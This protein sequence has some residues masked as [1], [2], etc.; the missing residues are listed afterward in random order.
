M[1][2]QRQLL[3]HMFFFIFF[4]SK[5]DISYSSSILYARL[6]GLLLAYSAGVVI[7][8]LLPVFMVSFLPGAADF[9]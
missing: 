9:T 6:P 2:L 1:F 3:L 4:L 7:Y 8:F 5:G